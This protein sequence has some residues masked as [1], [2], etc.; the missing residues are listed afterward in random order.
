MHFSYLLLALVGT[1]MAAPQLVAQQC[2]CCNL[3]TNK[4][5]CFNPP[6]SQGCNCPA[7]VCPEPAESRAWELGETVLQVVGGF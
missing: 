3:A 1:A 6:K 5:E 2:C 7:V 4:Y